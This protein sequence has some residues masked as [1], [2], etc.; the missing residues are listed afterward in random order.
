M[1]LCLFCC[2]P[3]GF[4]VSFLTSSSDP[5]EPGGEGSKGAGSQVPPGR[6]LEVIGAVSLQQ[7]AGVEQQ[8]KKGW[9]TI[10]GGRTER[11][12]ERERSSKGRLEH[13]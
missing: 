6:P 13:F 10:N 7:V 12:R 8:E 3:Q 11:E 2:T 4:S 9:K 5:E 1:S